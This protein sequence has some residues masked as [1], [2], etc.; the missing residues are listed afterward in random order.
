MNT[1][2]LLVGQAPA[3]VKQ[4]VPYDTT[5][6][7]DW[8]Q[9]VGVSKEQAQDIFIFDAVYDSFP[10]FDVNGGHLKPSKEQMDEYW[11]RSLFEKI[12]SVKTVI[13]LGN[14]SRD[15]VLSKGVK[16]VNYYFLP[17]PS[18]RN[19]GL[20]QKNKEQILSTLRTA[21]WT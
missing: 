2:I 16:D 7:Y 3:A 8:L 11:D 20:Y 14:V 1:K 5:Q 18:K 10:G 6:L 19:I 21:I 9:E 12:K 13:L 17:H 4:G 15:Y